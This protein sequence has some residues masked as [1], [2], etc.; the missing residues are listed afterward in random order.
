MKDRRFPWT[1]GC[2][3]QQGVASCCCRCG[4][5]FNPSELNKSTHQPCWKEG[6]RI[7]YPWQPTKEGRKF[8]H[9]WQPTKLYG[10]NSVC[11]LVVQHHIKA[12]YHVPARQWLDH[13]SLALIP[14]H[15]ATSWEK[16]ALTSAKAG[17][18]SSRCLSS[19][20]VPVQ[21]NLQARPC[22]GSLKCQS[23]SLPLQ[24]YGP[25]SMSRFPP[26]SAFKS[27]YMK[28]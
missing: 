4:I 3:F 18:S 10:W 17:H 20:K 25:S 27:G 7:A 8:T 12:S 11:V 26:F 22:L 1:S 21:H 16:R 24:L 5:E 28:G 9:P 13:T 14:E 19:P 2:A 23:P 6:R 15:C